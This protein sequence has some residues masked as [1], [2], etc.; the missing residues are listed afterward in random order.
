[1]EAGYIAGHRPD[2][3]EPTF[4]VHDGD[5]IDKPFAGKRKERGV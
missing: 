5:P 2:V 1:M 3:V 4:R